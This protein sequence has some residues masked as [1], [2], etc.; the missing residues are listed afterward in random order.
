MN[1]NLGGAQ[2]PHETQIAEI[3]GPMMV[4]NVCVCVLRGSVSVYRL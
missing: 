1:K 2:I 4:L 3:T